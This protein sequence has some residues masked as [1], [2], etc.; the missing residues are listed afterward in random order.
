MT[1]EQLRDA[2]SAQSFMSFVF[3]RANGREIPDLSH[4]F[5]LTVA[6][7]RTVVLASRMTY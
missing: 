1:V 7:G 5:I 2:Y 6:S 4:E 3:P